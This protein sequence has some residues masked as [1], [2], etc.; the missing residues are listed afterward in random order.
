[1]HGACWLRSRCRR[2]PSDVKQ[3]EPIRVEAA[4]TN[5]STAVW[6]P[7]SAGLGAVLLGCHVRYADGSMFRESYHWE[8]LTSGDGRNIL[9]GEKLSTVNVE[10][11]GLPRGQ[12]LLEFDLVSNDICW[13]AI[14]GSQVARV[15]V[16]V[17][18]LTSR[19]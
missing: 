1:M 3:G 10:L 2:P 5:N 13:Y 12:Y 14:N 7:R 16:E 15:D 6:L 19:G 9:A 4:V 17:A 18:A 8:A 11:P